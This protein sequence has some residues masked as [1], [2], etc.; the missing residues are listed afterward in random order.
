MAIS[1]VRIINKQS[2]A[3]DLPQMHW[4]LFLDWLGV[5]M[6]GYS[7]NWMGV[8]NLQWYIDRGLTQRVTR[9][10]TED[11]KLTGRKA[12][13]S[14]EYDEILQS[15]SCGRIDC[16]GDGLGPWG[17]EIGV[18][19]MKDSSWARF[20]KWL[21]NVETEWLWTLE[22]LVMFYEVENPKIEWWIEK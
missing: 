8:I 16:R 6:I 14:F 15:Y 1:V 20:G 17:A 2:R 5:K 18:D 22:D 12:G 10:L 13:E 11:S 9:T 4:Q 3:I 19:P 7:T 21:E